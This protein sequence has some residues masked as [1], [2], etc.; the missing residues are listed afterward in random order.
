M[1]DQT[2]QLATL[3]SPHMSD[4]SAAQYARIQ[5]VYSLDELPRRIPSERFLRTILKR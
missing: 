2:R 3:V 5:S 4:R 1:L